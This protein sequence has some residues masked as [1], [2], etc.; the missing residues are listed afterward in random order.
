MG[1]VSRITRLRFVNAYLVTE[2]DGYT[3]VDTM[4]PRSAKLILD[5]AA[6]TGRP[7]RRIVLTHAH[8]DHIGSLDALC[9]ALP[10]AEV[11]VSERDA[12]LLRKPPDRS[13]DPGEPQGKLRGG[14]P[15]AATAPTRTVVA[16]ER[17]GSLEV[18]ACPGHTPGHIALLDT[19]DRTLICGDA[20]TTFGGVLETTAR[21]G[22]RFPLATLATWDRPLELESARALRALEPSRL[23]VGHGKHLHEPVPAMDAAIAR[24]C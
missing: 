1:G 21:V 6:R 15:G 23:F 11:I 16:G 9:A 14:Y 3:L 20:F 19:R 13:L 5:T 24:A 2:D 8:G 7:I 4:V 17:I 22:W 10:Q 12:R 18:I